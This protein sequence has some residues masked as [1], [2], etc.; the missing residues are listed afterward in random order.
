MHIESL[1][2]ILVEDNSHLTLLDCTSGRLVLKVL[3]V[4]GRLAKTVEASMQ[5]GNQQIA[6]NMSDLHS[7]A[8][9][10]NAFFR[11]CFIKSFRFTKQ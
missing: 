6:L 4:Q 1:Q 7:G 9:V 5:E 8:Y 10:L 2:P 11:D 3:D